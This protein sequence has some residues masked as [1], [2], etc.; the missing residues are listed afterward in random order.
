MI[1][2]L[3]KEIIYE[4]KEIK[5]KDN[6]EFNLSHKKHIKEG[7]GDNNLKKKT[8]KITILILNKK[9]KE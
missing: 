9:K 7:I 3:I 6:N 2:L 5:E 4:E 1:S 8:M